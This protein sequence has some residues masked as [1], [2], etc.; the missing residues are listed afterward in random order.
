MCNALSSPFRGQS[1][2]EWC[3]CLCD[4]ESNLLSKRPRD[5]STHVSDDNATVFPFGFLKAM[6]LPIFNR[7]N[8]SL[9]ISALAKSRH[10]RE[11]PAVSASDS[12]KGRMWSGSGGQDVF[13]DGIL[14]HGR[15]SLRISQSRECGNDSALA[16]LR[17]KSCSAL[18]L[19]RRRLLRDLRAVL[20]WP[21]LSSKRV[22]QSP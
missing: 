11:K 21:S 1:A 5:Q 3:C 20:T 10:M 16:A 19:R 8:T 13:R 2:L 4:C 15:P 22:R 6:T 12:N 18:W 17:S 14:E 9:G 7:V